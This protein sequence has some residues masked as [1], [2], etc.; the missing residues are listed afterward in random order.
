LTLKIS[1]PKKNH[2]CVLSHFSRVRLSATPWT[3]ARKAALSM[4]FLSRQECWSGL[5]CP[6]P[7]DLP[8]TGI[9]LLMSPALAGGF[10]TTNTTWEAQKNAYSQAN[11]DSQ[12]PWLQKGPLTFRQGATLTAAMK[13]TPEPVETPLPR[14]P[15][16]SPHTQAARASSWPTTAC[17]HPVRPGPSSAVCQQAGDRA[18][19]P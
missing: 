4:G 6:P 8:N 1:H 16:P 15:S 5:P 3:V 2:V 12:S 11:G 18:C 19:A 14:L 17:P 7:G 9:E 13:H 10:F